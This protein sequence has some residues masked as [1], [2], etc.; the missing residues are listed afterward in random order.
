MVRLAMMP[1]E[2]LVLWGLQ[3]T[4]AELRRAGARPDAPR[5]F[6]QLLSSE[7]DGAQSDAY[8]THTEDNAS[9]AGLAPAGAVY[10]RL[11]YLD[12]D[13][14]V[15]WTGITQTGSEE[16]GDLSYCYEAYPSVG[17]VPTLEALVAR[18]PLP[19]Q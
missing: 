2:F 3:R 11:V 4:I 7:T 17:H 12:E 5:F 8:S 10:Y 15:K 13:G 6:V 18:F 19:L 14:E 16:E 1:R 9:D